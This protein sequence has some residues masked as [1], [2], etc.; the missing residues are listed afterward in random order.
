[1]E[2]VI[3]AT[4][5]PGPGALAD[6]PAFAV[7]A[8]ALL[9][10]L[11]WVILVQARHPGEAGYL[12]GDAIEYT[13]V[14]RSLLGGRGWWSPDSGGGPYLHGPLYPLFV[15]GVLAT[16]AALFWMTVAQAVIGAATCWGVVRLGR[17]LMA[18]A[19]A[20]AAGLAMAVYPY[21]F[22]Y[23]G[24]ILT[25]TLGVL[26]GFMVFASL[27][28]FS[29][30]PSWRRAA[31][32]GGALGLATLNHPETYLAPPLLLA[33]ALLFHPRRALVL[34]RLLGAFAVLA[35]CVLPWHAYHALRSGKN[36]FLPP[37]LDPGGVLAQGTLL[38]RGRITGDPAYD[39]HARELVAEGARLEKERGAL[40]G[41]EAAGKRVLGDLRE[42]P[43]GYLWLVSMKVRRMWT[44]APEKGV[45]SRP[46]IT[47]PTGALNVALYAGFLAGFLI[48][49]PREEAW[50]A[51]VLV[52][53][54]T[55]P[56]LIFYA[57]PRYRLPLMP[58]VS[59]FAG[60]ALSGA[61]E[62][63][64]ARRRVTGKMLTE[65]GAGEG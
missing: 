1:M 30:D 32:A 44:I 31:L 28:L 2:G 14:A 61:L 40:G 39:R 22:H 49:R 57:Q 42:D 37:A 15:S 4:K 13:T 9:S 36:V 55:L 29:R 18:P 21:Y 52:V 53:M 27:L 34:R 62:W 8:L 56:H 20:V 54:I 47:I 26:L 45:Y 7:F 60:V 11:A 23:A 46:W 12:E 19:G 65:G 6:V 35:L 33:W 50:L 24:R 25:E 41:L 48:H 58:M 17:R 5:S 38:A 43:R 63:I 10:R 16:G 59:L 51:P 64:A 3:D